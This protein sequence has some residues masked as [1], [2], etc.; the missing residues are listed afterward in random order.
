MSW[1]GVRRSGRPA[2]IFPLND[3]VVLKIVLDWIVFGLTPVFNN[4]SVMYR[5]VVYL[6]SFLGFRLVLDTN[7]RQKLP[8]VSHKEV[9]GR[10][11]ARTHDPSISE[12][13]VV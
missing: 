4:F 7:L 10:S 8:T 9:R 6:T 1:R 5:R 3:I 12:R 2:S 11:R 13:S